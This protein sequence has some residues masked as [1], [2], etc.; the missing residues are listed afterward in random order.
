MTVPGASGKL[1]RDYLNL[2]CIIVGAKSG[3]IQINCQNFLICRHINISL[4][5]ALISISIV[6]N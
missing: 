4:Y 6:F 1:N 5:G 3:F 2:L